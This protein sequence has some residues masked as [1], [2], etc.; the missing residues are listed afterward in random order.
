MEFN[1][2]S[3]LH[4]WCPLPLIDQDVTFMTICVKSGPLG[5]SNM[6]SFLVMWATLQ[7]PIISPRPESK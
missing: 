7:S 1:F 5:P 3:P 4:W 2:I 6:H